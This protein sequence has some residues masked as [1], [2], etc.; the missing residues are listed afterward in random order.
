MC[1]CERERER[2]KKSVRRWINQTLAKSLQT[3]H[4]SKRTHKETTS[5]TS[6]YSIPCKDYNKYYMVSSI[7]IYN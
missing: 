2:E 7:S 4:I 3:S 5:H 6:I 1:V